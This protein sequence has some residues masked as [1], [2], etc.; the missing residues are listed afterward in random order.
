MHIAMLFVFQ[1]DFSKLNDIDSHS[2]YYL[3]ISIDV[4]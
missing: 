1:I 4:S 2:Y 3:S